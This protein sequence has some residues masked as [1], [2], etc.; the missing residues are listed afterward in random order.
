MYCI[1]ANFANTY[2]QIN[3]ITRKFKRS[4]TVNRDI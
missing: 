2:K 4:I 1:A 3:Y